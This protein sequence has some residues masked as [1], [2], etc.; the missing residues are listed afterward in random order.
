MPR[1]TRIYSIDSIQFAL[2]K[3]MPPSLLVTAFGRASSTGWSDIKLESL[4]K[5]LS[6]D[7]ILDLAFVGLPPQEVFVPY[8][9]PVTAHFVWKNA[10]EVIG[11]KIHARSNDLTRLILEN[12]GGLTTEKVGE[13]GPPTTQIAGE[14]QAP[15]EQIAKTLAIGEE[16]LTTLALGEEHPHHPPT[17]WIVGEETPH[18]TTMLGEEFPPTHV[19][20]IAEGMTFTHGE[21]PA[22]LPIIENP[23]STITAET[24]PWG[25]PGGPVETGGINPFG[26]R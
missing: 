16:H 26:R 20:P 15:T 25:D 11:V 17:T 23:P 8:L 10:E 14:G 22:S 3:S 12:R 4:E 21:H 1:P 24:G 2:T 7:G 13:E 19:S 9:A 6:P 5:T 18:T